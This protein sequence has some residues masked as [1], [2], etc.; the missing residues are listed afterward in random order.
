MDIVKAVKSA[1]AEGLRKKNQDNNADAFVMIFRL[2]ESKNDLANILRL[3]EDDI[4]SVIHVHCLG[5]PPSA[6]QHTSGQLS[7]P[8]K[9]QLKSAYDKNWV[10]RNAKE[11]VRASGNSSIRIA[12]CLIFAEL[13][14]LKKLR[15]DCSSLNMSSSKLPNGKSRYLEIDDRIMQK[16]NNGKLAYFDNKEK[17]SMQP[18]KSGTPAPAVTS[19][20]K[21]VQGGS[22]VTP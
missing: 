7:R 4:Q 5:K 9:F 10:V 22:P 15:Q 3:L 21:N 13:D 14:N 2:L 20:S 17:T 18:S 16:L 12:K 6:G 11:L 19:V 1:V 8:I